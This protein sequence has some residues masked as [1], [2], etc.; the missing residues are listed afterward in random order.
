LPSPAL[1]A[2]KLI[3][4]VSPSFKLNGKLVDFGKDT[5]SDL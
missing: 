2:P 4:V 1:I 3:D 5:I